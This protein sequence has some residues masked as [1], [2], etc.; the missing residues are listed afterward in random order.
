MDGWMDGWMDGSK[1]FFKGLLGAVQI[2]L[3]T[4]FGGSGSSLPHSVRNRPIFL[5]SSLTLSL[6]NHVRALSPN[7]EI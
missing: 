6:T 5:G 4:C 7:R 2:D 1:D 3:K